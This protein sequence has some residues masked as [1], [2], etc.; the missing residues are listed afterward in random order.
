MKERSARGGIVAVG[1][2]VVVGLGVAGVFVSRATVQTEPEVRPPADVA[3]VYDPVTAGD[4]LPDGFRQLLA[5]DQIEPV[6]DPMFTTADR[7][8]WPLEMLVLGV[9]GENT[10]KAY[11][12]THLNQHEMVIDHLDGSPILVS[13]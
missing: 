3:A 1:L 8:D 11:P 9:A 7:V 4:A 10:S 6:Y 13:W 5:R 12:V 2:A